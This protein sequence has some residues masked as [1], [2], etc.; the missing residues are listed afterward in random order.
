MSDELKIFLV[1]DAVGRPGREL[2]NKVVPEYRQSGEADFVIANGENSAHGKGI[3]SETA[4][5]LFKSGVDVITLGNHAW[6]N[7]DVFNF[8]EQETRLL[9]PANFGTAPLVPGRGWG[10]FSLPGREDVKIGVINLIGRVHIG[11][12]HCPFHEVDRILAELQPQTSII[13]VDFHAEATS[14]KIAMGWY[15]NGR[16][17]CMF[18]THTHV[19]TADEQILDK[20]TAYITDLG[21]TGGHD[22]VIGVKYPEVISKF[23]SNLPAKFNV[24]DGMLKLNGALVTIDIETGRATDIRRVHEAVPPAAA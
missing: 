18:G 21:M 15:L 3:T 1:G 9:R 14:E 10:V 16:V 6:D 20:G 19:S 24:A 23:L 13:V 12:S 17:S 5:D 8:I 2:I 4:K 7:K 11:G 22:G